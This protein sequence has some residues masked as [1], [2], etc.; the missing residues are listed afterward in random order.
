[1]HHLYFPACPVKGP[2][3]PPVP[4]YHMA[5]V[6]SIPQKCGRCDFSFERSCTRYLEQIQHYMHLD[7]GPCGI[8]GPTDPVT[9]NGQFDEVL[10]AQ[11][12]VPRK[13]ARCSFL[14]RDGIFGFTCKKDPEKWGKF[15]RGLDWGHWSPDRFFI[16]L[17]LPKQT[18]KALVDHAHTNDLLEFIKE[19]RRINPA[20]SMAEAK[21][22]FAD[23]R[24]RLAQL[25]AE[26]Q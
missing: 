17:G 10:Q 16:E 13:C 8:E 26:R 19:Y 9:Y 7:Y 2:I 24:N 15:H 1:M 22:D 18:T 21:K 11:V 14:F 20:R 23:M 4:F 6:G 12:E 3:E 25:E 5:S